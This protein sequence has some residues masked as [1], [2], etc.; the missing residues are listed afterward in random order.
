MCVL[1]KTPIAFIPLAKVLIDCVLI[2][3]DE[4]TMAHKWGV[5]GLRLNTAWYS[6][7]MRGITLVF[8]GD[9]RQTLPVVPSGIRSN[10]INASLKSFTVWSKVSQ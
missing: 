8:A 3:W 2:V 9:F 5:G 1:W 4:C 6:A 10:Q 7:N